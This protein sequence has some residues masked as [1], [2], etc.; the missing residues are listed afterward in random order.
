MT[1]QHLLCAAVLLASCGGGDGPS[2][3]SVT[4]SSSVA[5]GVSGGSGTVVSDPPGINC[6]IASGA[7]TGD[8]STSFDKDTVVSL[9]ATVNGGSTF[10]GWLNVAS[11]TDFD[12]E[13][14]LGFQDQASLST[15]PLPLDV[16]EDRDLAVLASF[17]ITPAP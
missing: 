13:Q 6:N 16:D 15:N 1:R 12:Y 8:C 11:G 14:T 17:I 5:T 7:T 10:G 2:T 9:T 3:V 4:G